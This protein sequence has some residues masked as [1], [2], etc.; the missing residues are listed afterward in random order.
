M[1]RTPPRAGAGRRRALA[2]I[3]A[4]AA[5]WP[6][7]TALAAPAASSA[8]D[9]SLFSRNFDGMQLVDQDNRRFSFRALKGKVLLVNFVY[10][11]CSTICP[12]Q[13]RELV[14][15]QRALPESQRQAVHFV[16]VSLDPLQ[17]T[18]AALKAFAQRQSADLSHWS[19]VTG[20]EADLTRLGEHLR[21]FRPGGRKPDDHSTALWLV[22]ARGR[23]LQRLQGNPPDRLRLARELNAM[24][25][26]AAKPGSAAR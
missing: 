10:T 9:A 22:D 12:V 20:R 11:G 17:D 4:G 13:T 19:F 3:L 7:A 26:L 25:T 8:D 21:L 2:A 5:V 16:S 23:L 14:E 18:P 15:L 1:K 24:S 6:A